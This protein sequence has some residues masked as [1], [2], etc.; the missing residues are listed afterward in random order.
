VHVSKHETQFAA[1]QD[2]IFDWQLV[3]MHET[4]VEPNIAACEALHD[5]AS[6]VALPLLPPLLLPPPS[7]PL[8]DAS[9]PSP[10]DES[11]DEHAAATA[12][13]EQSANA[14]LINFMVGLQ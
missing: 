13:T 4:H 9:A 1:V 6:L 14:T 5:P 7:P 10:L 8:V 3:S 2:A 12:N 11:L